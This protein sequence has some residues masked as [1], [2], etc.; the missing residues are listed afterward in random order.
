MTFESMG[1]CL[2]DYDGERFFC[3]YGFRTK[4]EVYDQIHSYLPGEKIYLEL[5]NQNYYHLDTC[6]S[7]VNKETAFY[8]KSAF[9]EAGLSR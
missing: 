5:I 8:V 2:E 4:K 3:G 6:L 9:S 1:D 7:I